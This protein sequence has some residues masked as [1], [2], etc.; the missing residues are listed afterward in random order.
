MSERAAAPVTARGRRTRDA[1]LAAARATFETRGFT[2]TTMSD[3]A[4]AAS[5]S[6]GTVYTYF[7]NKDAVLTAVVDDLAAEV[8]VAL[9]VGDDTGDDPIARIAAANQRYLDAHER[10]ARL[11]V[12]VEHAA[13]TDP[14]YR[15]VLDGLRAGF[16]DRAVRGLRRLQRDGVADPALDPRIAGEALCGMVE[17]YARRQTQTGDPLSDPTTLDTLNRLWAQAI[18]L[19]HHRVNGARR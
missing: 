1:V 15:E 4:D 17:S 9:R 16:V 8:V 19:P 14:H 11:I 13:T 18:G 12:V 5:V 7:P 2:D 10:H 3:I 6:H